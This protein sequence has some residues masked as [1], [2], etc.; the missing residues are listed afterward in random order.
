MQLRSGKITNN[1]LR[2]DG[3]Y[4]QIGYKKINN[5]YKTTSD[6]WYNI[7]KVIDNNHTIQIGNTFHP[8]CEINEDGV[9]FVKTRNIKDDLIIDLNK[10]NFDIYNIVNQMQYVDWNHFITTDDIYKEIPICE[11]YPYDKN[12]DDMKELKKIN[13]KIVDCL[14]VEYKHINDNCVYAIGPK[15]EYFYS[16]YS[17]FSKQVINKVIMIMENKVP[18]HFIPFSEKDRE[19]YPAHQEYLKWLK[20]INGKKIKVN[21]KNVNKL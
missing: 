14:Y 4:V 2:V 9:H 5:V 11:T 3:V 19:K 13:S 15:M 17:P 18:F 1:K 21:N 8:F 6:K 7:I 16:W 10:N 20:K 12:N